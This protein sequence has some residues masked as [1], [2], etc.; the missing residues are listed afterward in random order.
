MYQYS[1]QALTVHDG[2][3]FTADVDLG[4]SVHTVATFRLDGLDAP[5]LK[6]KA[7]KD[8]A[9]WVKDRFAAHGGNCIVSTR[10]DLREKY[11]R[12]LAVVYFP[13]EA[14]SLNQQLIDTGRAKPYSG[15]KR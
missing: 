13:G 1:A 8:V 15:G 7:G 9:A 2:D 4:F 10:K 12:M 3:T 5:E 6:T 11:G 14:T